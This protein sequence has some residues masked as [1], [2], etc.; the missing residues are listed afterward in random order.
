MNIETIL[1]HDE[2]YVPHVYL[3]S[4]GYQTIGIG[5]LVDKRKGGGITREEALYLL[6]NDIDRKSAELDAKLP[7]WRHE[8]TIR[9]WAMLSMAFNLGVNGL[10]G[11]KKMLTAWK[12]KDYAEAKRQ[13]LDSKWATQVKSRAH[14]IAHMIEHDEL[15]ES[16]R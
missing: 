6:R 12:G 15:P 13:A 14:R 2:R 8:S 9:Q 7:W 5:R 3:D 11:F 4:E 10:L 16:L 1:E